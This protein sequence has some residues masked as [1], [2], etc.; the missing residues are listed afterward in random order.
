[1]AAIIE[2]A[3]VATAG[4]GAGPHG[5]GILSDDARLGWPGLVEL[6]KRVDTPSPSPG[7]NPRGR[8]PFAADRGTQAHGNN[9]NLAPVARCY[10]RVGQAFLDLD[11]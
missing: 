6:P 4:R 8:S 1:M 5:R 2:L 11:K 7:L 10:F 9:R 3:S